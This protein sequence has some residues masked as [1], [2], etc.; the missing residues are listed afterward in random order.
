M[1]ASLL[2]LLPFSAILVFV[3]NSWSSD[4]RFCLSSVGLPCA[5]RV[6]RKQMYDES[7]D[8]MAHQEPEHGMSSFPHH[9]VP[10]DIA[11]YRHRNLL[12]IDID[13]VHL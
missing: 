13:V 9:Y 11:R 2:T 7:H 5:Y 6:P 12:I 4:I 3:M 8:D 1:P 10:H